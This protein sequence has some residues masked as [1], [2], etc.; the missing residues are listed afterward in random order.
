MTFMNHVYPSDVCLDSINNMYGRM[1]D[2]VTYIYVHSWQIT[3]YYS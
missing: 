2:T 1:S 3:Y